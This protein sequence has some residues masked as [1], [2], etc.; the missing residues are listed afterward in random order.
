MGPGAHL[1]NTKQR[2][3]SARVR[4]RN[5]YIALPGPGVVFVLT[6]VSDV[7]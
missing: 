6:L 2:G 3:F 7:S 4:S 5:R 1:D